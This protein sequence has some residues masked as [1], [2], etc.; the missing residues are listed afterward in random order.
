MPPSQ[1][2]DRPNPFADWGTPADPSDGRR[3]PQARAPRARAPRQYPSSTWLLIGAVAILA[4]V[5]AFVLSRSG[6]SPSPSSLAAAAVSPGAPAA[7][8]GGGPSDA[9]F[10]AAGSRACQQAND[11]VVALPEP[12]TEAQ[13][14]AQIRALAPIEAD[15]VAA[16]AR[17]HAPASAATD[18]AAFQREWERQVVLT[19]QVAAAMRSGDHAAV[20]SFSNRLEAASIGSQLLARGL[21]LTPC[22]EDPQPSNYP[23]RTASQRFAASLD[24][25]CSNAQQTMNDTLIDTRATDTALK[26][27]TIAPASGLAQLSSQARSLAADYTALAASLGSVPATSS[28]AA[29]VARVQASLG[30]SS[31]YAGRLAIALVTGPLT[32]IRSLSNQ[33]DATARTLE[34]TAAPLHAYTC[35]NNL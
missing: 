12:F 23:A 22:T 32:A 5:G 25:V 34:S 6:G 29:I 17:L 10:V 3:E 28:Q 31:A 16:F 21:G 18:F 8:G 20:H 4:G 7:G 24:R 14:T 1:E 13:L 2:P 35:A 26:A 15:A 9:S 11:R 30:L 33:L 19:R 27:H